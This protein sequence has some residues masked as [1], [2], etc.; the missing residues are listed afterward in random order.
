MIYG[1]DASRLQFT[2][3]LNAEPTLAAPFICQSRSALPARCR[4]FLRSA[5]WTRSRRAAGGVCCKRRRR[6]QRRRQHERHLSVTLTPS[7]LLA[8]GQLWC[9]LGT[10]NS[11]R[12]LSESSLDYTLDGAATSK[13]TAGDTV[14]ASGRGPISGV[15]DQSID[16]IRMLFIKHHYL[17]ARPLSVLSQC[18]YA[19]LVPKYH[20]GKFISGIPNETSP[21]NALDMI[22]GHDHG[23]VLRRVGMLQAKTS[24]FK[25]L[26]LVDGATTIWHSLTTR[27]GQKQQLA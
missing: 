12:I 3:R 7:T 26:K 23:T 13:S 2:D 21:P 24:C 19:C 27:L 15:V 14:S 25:R 17:Q 20:N 6:C 18:T 11:N 5:T 4:R 22:S 9:P 1:L 16:M 8:R 10:Y